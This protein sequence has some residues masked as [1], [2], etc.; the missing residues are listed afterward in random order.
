MGASR[1]DKKLTKSILTKDELK[2]SMAHQHTDS[3]MDS[4]KIKLAQSKSIIL[5]E[6]DAKKSK[7]YRDNQAAKGNH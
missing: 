7:N 4:K 3:K 5:T 2:S 1:L 6:K